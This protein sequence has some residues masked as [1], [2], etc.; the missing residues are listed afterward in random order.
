MQP[1]F[2]VLSACLLHAPRA[3]LGSVIKQSSAEAHLEG[4]GSLL[5]GALHLARP[6]GAQVAPFACAAAVALSRCQVLK[7]HC[8]AGNLGPVMP[9]SDL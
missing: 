3:P 8:T 4:E 5:K 7:A 1:F 2:A 6:K 9:A